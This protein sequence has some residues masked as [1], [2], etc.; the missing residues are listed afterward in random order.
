MK[1]ELLLIMQELTPEQLEELSL[2]I[3]EI[4]RRRELA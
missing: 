3:E 1:E 2:L 4:L